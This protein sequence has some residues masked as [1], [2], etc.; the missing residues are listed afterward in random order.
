MVIG[1]GVV[2]RWFWKRTQQWGWLWWFLR[3]WR[4][5]WRRWKQRQLV[6]IMEI[7]IQ[8]YEQV[9]GSR[10]E[11]LRYCASISPEHLVQPL[12]NFG[13]SSIRNLLVHISNS[14]IYWLGEFALNKTVT[15]TKPESV[16]TAQEIALVFDQVD[17]L[18]AEFIKAFPDHSK[19]M[20]GWVKWFKKDLDTTPLQLYTHVITH[21]FHHKGQI[22]TMS[23]HL[24]YTPVDID[25]IRF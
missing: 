17:L 18:M 15:Y 7:L 3:R 20:T 1:I 4:R 19:P 14:S 21:L 2:R 22:M 6:A 16:H 12:Q 24:G 23:R 5:L 9:K 10:N 8:Q 13:H 11:L 25:V